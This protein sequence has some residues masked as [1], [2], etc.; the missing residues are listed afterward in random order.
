LSAPASRF[1]LLA[2]LVLGP[3]LALALVD[4]AIARSD[5]LWSWVAS[6][7]PRRLDDHYRAEAMLRTLPP[8]RDQVLV[9]G[10]SRADDSIDTVE[11]SSRFAER[12]LRFENLT[13]VG[14]G[15]V[16]LAMRAPALARHEPGA[17]VVLLDA[18]AL[19]A[20]KVSDETFAYDAAVAARVFSA[21]EIA[22]EPGFHVAGLAGQLHLLARHR[23]SLQNSLLVGL[24]RSTF[25]RLQIELVQR[26]RLEDGVGDESAEGIHER[27][28]RN[29]LVAWMKSREPDRWPNANTRALEVLAQHMRESG[30]RL[31]A[32]ESPAHPILVAPG[33][34]MR[35]ERFRVEVDALA[36]KHGFAFLPATRFPEL[37]TH[38]FKDLIHVNEDGRAVFT[39]ALGDLLAERL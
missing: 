16:D 14:S 20:E 29:E 2:L 31:F 38:H 1:R 3:I 23:R 4:L 6:D 12:G 13:V 30:T 17:I 33:I 35:I 8:G 22:A 36:E 27:R 15:V 19:R 37:D 10:N 7:F 28:A 9:L 32:I 11:L 24:G 34:A 21:A 18:A 26:A 25:G 5:A 39:R